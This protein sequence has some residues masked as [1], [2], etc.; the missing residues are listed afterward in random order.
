MALALVL[1]ISSGLMI[2]T[3]QALR[4]VQ[5]GFTQPSEIQTLRISIPASQVKE[6]ERVVRMQND[7]L[8]RIASI[9]GVV[10]VA[11]ANSVPTDGMGGMNPIFAEGRTYK[12]GE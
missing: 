2:R 6:P 9:P 3:F 1:L 10:S 7:I 12:E 5:P 11:I 8:D 4:T